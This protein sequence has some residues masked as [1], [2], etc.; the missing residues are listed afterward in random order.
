[1]ALFQVLERIGSVAYKLKLPI[2]SRIHPVFHISLLKRAVGDY[3]VEKE[4]PKELANDPD[5]VW[6]P[7]EILA[8]RS[9]NKG[10]EKSETAAD[11]LERQGHC[12]S[13]LR[14]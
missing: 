12:R 9:I 4:L 14:G 10:G 7:M 13:Y 2:D 11:P 8:T 5:S 3:H 6:E 1:M